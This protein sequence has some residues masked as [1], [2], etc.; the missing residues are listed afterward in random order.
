[1]LGRARATMSALLLLMLAACNQANP[2]QKAGGNGG[3]AS[4][5]VA[6]YFLAK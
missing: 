3:P 1:M 2:G 5:A 6:P 4:R